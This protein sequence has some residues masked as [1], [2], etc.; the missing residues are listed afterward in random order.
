MISKKKKKNPQNPP[1]K[2]LLNLISKKSDKSALSG[3]GKSFHYVGM[4]HN[5]KDDLEWDILNYDST[6]AELLKYLRAKKDILEGVI[7][8]F[9]RLG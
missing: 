7:T 6:K 9:V 3:S 4:A 5:I 2:D 8:D 1:I